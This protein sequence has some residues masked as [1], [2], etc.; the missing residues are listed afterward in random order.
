[1]NN[2]ENWAN[3]KDTYLIQPIYGG[4]GR[5]LVRCDE[6]ESRFDCTQCHGKGTTGN[7]CP[8]CKGNG[9]YRGKNNTEDRCTT[10]YI[11]VGSMLGSVRGNTV[12]PNAS[13]ALEHDPEKWIPVFGKDHAPPIM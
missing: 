12:E 5:V 1:M 10:C 9:R 4:E 11:V 6:F 2:K 7:T 13:I 8:E 3:I